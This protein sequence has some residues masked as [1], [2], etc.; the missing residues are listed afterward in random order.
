MVTPRHLLQITILVIT[1][2]DTEK[3][4]LKILNSN[5]KKGLE[6]A[7]AQCKDKLSNFGSIFVT[8]G[9]VLKLSKFAG[10]VFNSVIV[11]S[12]TTSVKI[13]KVKKLRFYFVQKSISKYVGSK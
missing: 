13:K 7:T 10:S 4:F 12:C 11:V 8:L 3:D 6:I 2:F 9:K 1:P 5:N